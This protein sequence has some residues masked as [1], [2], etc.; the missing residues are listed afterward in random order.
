MK[1]K[2]NLIIAVLAIA[3]L[4]CQQ[5]KNVETPPLVDGNIDD[6][7][8]LAEPIN[9]LEGTDLYFYQNDHYVWIAYDYPEGSYGTLDLK[10]LAPNLT[11]T[12]NIHISAQLG[13]WY[14]KAGAPKPENSTSELWWNHEGWYANEVWMNGLNREEN[15]KGEEDVT[16]NWRNAEAR[17]IQISK[18]RF[19]RGEWNLQLNIRAIQSTDEFT[20]ITFPDEGMYTLTIF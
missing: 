6:I 8:L 14:L 13:E 15:E 5:P 20:S 9:L 18:E 1:R 19:G 17:E 3:T 7:K 11:D 4:A 2:P 12:L 10:L 16:P